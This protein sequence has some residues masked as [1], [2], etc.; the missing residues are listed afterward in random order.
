MSTSICAVLARTSAGT[1]S[2][3][4]AAYMG[5]KLA[6]TSTVS[7]PEG[8]LSSFYQRQIVLQAALSFMQPASANR[9]VGPRRP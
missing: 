6:Q 1:S 2:T 4:S 9:P 5:T 3:L 7:S 8:L